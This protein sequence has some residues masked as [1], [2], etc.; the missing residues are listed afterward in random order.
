L[1][2]QVL[3]DSAKTLLEGVETI[4]RAIESKKAL[5]NAGDEKMI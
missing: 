4:K 1:T 2:I 5:L 3:R